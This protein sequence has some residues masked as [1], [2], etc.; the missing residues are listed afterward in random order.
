MEYLIIP[1]FQTL[2]GEEAIEAL[3]EYI[4]GLEEQKPVELTKK[5]TNTLIK[6]A[7]GLIARAKQKLKNGSR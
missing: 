4:K 5:Q 6:F 2:R 3:T 1:M 7:R